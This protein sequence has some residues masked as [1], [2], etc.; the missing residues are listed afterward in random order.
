MVRII[1]LKSA[2]EVDVG[3]LEKVEEGDAS[4]TWRNVVEGVEIMKGVSWI[5]K[6]S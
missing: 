3:A 4:T 6:T 1:H 5:G 2:G